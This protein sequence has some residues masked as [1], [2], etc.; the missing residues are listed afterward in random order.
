VKLTLVLKGF[1]S[2]RSE[3]GWVGVIQR[4]RL[5]WKCP[6]QSVHV[7]LGRK[8]G[9][10]RPLTL[11]VLPTVAGCRH[12]PA[13]KMRFLQKMIRLLAGRVRSTR[14]PAPR[15]VQTAGAPCHL[16][17]ECMCE[18]LVA[19][20]K[21]LPPQ[22]IVSTCRRIRQGTMLEA[23]MAKACLQLRR[24]LHHVLCFCDECRAGEPNSRK[25]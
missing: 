6:T 12:L 19:D 8:H 2:L 25:L 21:L 10:T 13:C 14:S 3:G 7:A 15:C 24:K 9:N 18:G 5:C 20:D 11:Q 1:S 23:A 17:V 16:L 4:H 22:V